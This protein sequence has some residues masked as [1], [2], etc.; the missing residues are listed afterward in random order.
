MAWEKI[1]TDASG[2]YPLFGAS[3]DDDVQFLPLIISDECILIFHAGTA[4]DY[5]NFLV[6]EWSPPTRVRPI[7][8]V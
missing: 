8:E 6:L 1:S 4:A 2:V 7:P 3:T 5:A